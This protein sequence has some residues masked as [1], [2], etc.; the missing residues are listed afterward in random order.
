MPL[1]RHV[2]SE[3]SRA[4]ANAISMTDAILRE[5]IRTEYE[6]WLFSE[7]KMCS[8]VKNLLSRATR[9][10]ED[11]QL[12]DAQNVTES[13]GSGLSKERLERLSQWLQDYCESCRLESDFLQM[14]S[15]V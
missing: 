7:N 8:Q 12:K 11:Q 4:V 5:T 6:S 1:G 9:R 2:R 15:P 14:D 3:V 10:R 13:H